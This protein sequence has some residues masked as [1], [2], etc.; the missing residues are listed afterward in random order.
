MENPI[1]M[2]D[3]GVPLFLET[4]I[5]VI[6]PKNEGCGFPWNLLTVVATIFATYSMHLIPSTA[7]PE[8]VTFVTASWFLKISP[9]NSTM[10]ELP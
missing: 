6:T 3:L 1:Q 5:W 7:P 8:V 9:K 2:D 4:S 10:F